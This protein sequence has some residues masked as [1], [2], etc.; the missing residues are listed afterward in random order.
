MTSRVIKVGGSLLDWPLLG[1]RLWAWLQ[2]LPPGKNYLLAGGGDLADAIRAADA[3][4]SLDEA[5]CHELCLEAM[6][7]SGKLLSQLL[8]AASQRP[9]AAVD[10]QRLIQVLDA[11]R[12]LEDPAIVSR[13]GEL[14]R[15]WKVTSDSLAAY[16]ARVFRASQLV[17]LKS[18]DLPHSM[19]FHEASA[20]GYVDDFFPTAAREVSS[21][22]AVNLRSETPSDWLLFP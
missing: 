8:S 13:G 7:I 20:C 19:T 6:S 9:G 5:F 12:L 16:F 22:R 3:T 2:Q 1:D 17:L 14:P 10:Q 4:H 11:R 15:T 21:V 18:A